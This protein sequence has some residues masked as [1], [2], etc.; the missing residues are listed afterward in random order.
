MSERQIE[1]NQGED[2]KQRRPAASSTASV[3]DHPLL[4]LQQQAG[5][6]TVQSALRA[7]GSQAKLAIGGLDDPEEREADSTAQR[8]VE[9]TEGKVTEGSG[10]S[11]VRKG[12]SSTIRRK[13]SPPYTPGTSGK[14]RGATD[15]L[16]G[17]FQG[18]RS[19]DANT[20]A[21]FEPRFGR[22]FS[23]VRVHDNEGAD[24]A[25]REI[26]ARAFTS[27]SDIAFASG[28]FAPETGAGK[29]LLAHE[30]T[31]VVQQESGDTRVR[32]DP[33][34]D[35]PQDAP[36]P[37][38][39]E[40][41][42]DT[43]I[44]QID[45]SDPW[46]HDSFRLLLM[47]EAAKA[48]WINEAAYDNFLQDR[49][50]DSLSAG[51]TKDNLKD[52]ESAFHSAAVEAALEDFDRKTGAASLRLMV[53][54]QAK[55]DQWTNREAF[56]ELLDNCI[57]I[58]DTE[59]S[60]AKEFGLSDLSDRQLSPS[61]E[62]AIL[63]S[64]QAHIVYPDAFPETWCGYLAK[65]LTMA[66]S[67]TY[68]HMLEKDAEGEM[69]TLTK[70]GDFIPGDILRHGLPLDFPTSLDLQD[71]RLYNT[72]GIVF[73][74][75]ASPAGE[76]YGN[77]RSL[78]AFSGQGIR[79]LRAVSQ[80]DFTNLWIEYAQ[81]IVQEVKDGD[82]WVDPPSFVEYKHA[83]PA[84]VSLQ[85]AMGLISGFP[86]PPT[87]RID[88]RVAERYVTNLAGL[89]AAGKSFEHA[90]VVT[91]LA[92]RLLGD[93]DALIAN[94]S[95]NERLIR[96][97][98]W[99]HE[100]GFYSDAL[101][102]EWT[103]VKDHLGE[104]AADMGKDVALFTT[105]QFVPVVDVLVDIYAAASL[106]LDV[107]STLEDV[108]EV[109]Q[110][111]RN[112]TT[113]VA[114]QRA[115]A[116]RASVLSSAARKVAT[117]IAAH[118]ASKL[119]SKAA[120]VGVSKAKDWVSK[121]SADTSTS[122]PPS[123][124]SDPWDTTRPP[125]PKNAP[126][127]PTPPAAPAAPAPDKPTAS[128]QPDNASGSAP[129]V[130]PKRWVVRVGPDGKP[131]M[132]PAGPPHTVPDFVPDPDYVP[133]QEGEPGARDIQDLKGP[134]KMRTSA[135]NEASLAA[136]AATGIPSLISGD[137]TVMTS[138]DF[139]DV[140]PDQPTGIGRPAP[141]ALDLGRP[142]GGSEIQNA[143]V[144]Q[145]IAMLRQAGATDFR[146]NQRQTV[147]AQ[148]AGTNRPDLSCVLNGRRVHLEYDRFPMDRAIEHARRILTNDPHAI[149]ILKGIDY[150]TRRR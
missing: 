119:A 137:G 123:P 70:T 51:D 29:K 82:L 122:R 142:V 150:D 96:A 55:K 22:D 61:Q 41:R 126:D 136:A 1:S 49:I 115:A 68:P 88:P 12:E 147:G 116:H 59:Q 76:L 9:G 108:Y 25:A 15:N 103:D 75:L 58:A 21:F 83:R 45:L 129:P 65:Y 73:S 43:E 77:G 105:L 28:E 138:A 38:D 121:G 35:V 135:S 107:A 60:T 44:E 24:H 27:G 50:D 97:E 128:G 8:V 74:W 125:A 100:Q 37:F 127:T 93:A 139:P 90:K 6:Q 85:E 133:D 17:A 56:P 54:L 106:I 99:A 98:D 46:K 18:G 66:E 42:V 7:S 109:D 13:A 94:Q 26:S 71:F 104:I 3:P 124:P 2:R 141:G 79:Y 120:R 39:A 40:L 117:A 92:A 11:E 23:R 149:V 53:V 84:G 16:R 19:L 4:H 14:P 132:T 78:T 114:L 47:L 140:L 143:E 72:L 80:A 36:A 81:S 144:Q 86:S 91:E 146:V 64:K 57:A 134:Q 34:P 10:S 95:K 111:A 32:R 87:G 148:Q 102:K 30:L 130:R 31:H 67:S 118:K 131:I 113:A 62:K 101:D 48:D 63:E 5:N 89:V 110:E 52:A 33:Q 69:A 20:R 145:D 112:A